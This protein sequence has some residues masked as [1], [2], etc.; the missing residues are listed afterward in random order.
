MRRISSFAVDGWNDGWWLAMK[1]GVQLESEIKP[2]RNITQQTEG[3]DGILTS[4][5]S[6][7][8]LGIISK[9]SK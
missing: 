4:I 5:K 9:E 2:R 7:A 6:L 3:S 1:T 8:I